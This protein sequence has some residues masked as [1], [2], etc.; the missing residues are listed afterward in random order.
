MRVLRFCNGEVL[1]NT[2]GVCL[3]ILDALGGD[4]PGWD[5]IAMATAGLSQAKTWER[6]G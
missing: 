3:T 1:T 5:A 6:V 4:R 2:N